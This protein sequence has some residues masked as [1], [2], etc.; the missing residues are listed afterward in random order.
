LIITS[1]DLRLKGVTHGFFTREGGVSQGIF[2][3]LNCGLGSGD[4]V[5]LVTENRARVQAKLG[6]SALVSGYQVHGVDVAVITGP[7]DERPKVDGM[8]SAT[9]GVALG[10]LSADCGPVLFADE[11]AKVVGA[12]HAGWKGAL[13]GVT[14]TTVEAMERL[15][16]SRENIV[17]VL[18]PTISKAN[19]EV[20]PEFPSAFRTANSGTQIYFTPSVKKDHHM[21]DLPRFLVDRMKAFGVGHVADLALC[22]Y[23]EEDWFF[24]YRRATHRGEKDYGRL[25]SAIGLRV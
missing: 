23:A 3:S 15:G 12:C 22:T 18:G 6:V 4:D 21:F 1:D 25:I 10:I 5:A 13:L 14:D 9:P 16:A 11:K 20:G 2:A 7:M 19:Y 8:V 17:A 24:S